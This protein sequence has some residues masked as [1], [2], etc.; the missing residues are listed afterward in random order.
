M[1]E[2]ATIGRYLHLLGSKAVAFTELR[3][4]L[5]P[6]PF[7]WIILLTNSLMVHFNLTWHRYMK[8]LNYTT[9]LSLISTCIFTG[10]VV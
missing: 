4:L 2:V 1:P 6:C 3:R 9:L 5:L 8:C 10:R 7:P